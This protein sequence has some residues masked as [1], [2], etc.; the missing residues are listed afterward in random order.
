MALDKITTDIIA[1]NA[2]TSAKIP[3]GAIT[4]SDLGHSLK[5]TD[6]HNLTG[7]YSVHEMIMGKTF[8]LT[9]NVTVNTNLVLVNMSGTGDD[10]T[11]LDDGTATTITGTGTLEG[12]EMLGNTPQRTSLT[13][14]TGE[15]GSV[16]T[17]SP[18]LNL[19]TGTL[20]SGVTFPAGHIL[21]TRH[22]INQNIAASTGNTLITAIA[23]EISLSNASNNIL[24]MSTTP[25][26]YQTY[27]GSSNTSGSTY[28]GFQVRSSGTGVSAETHKWG[29]WSSTG[30]YGYGFSIGSTNELF[31]KDLHNAIWL[32][33]PGTTNP[34]TITVEATGKDD[35]TMT[36]NYEGGSQPY[37]NHSVMILHEIQV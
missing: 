24:V 25:F 34:T 20:G 6:S 32:F 19:T 29:S 13:G 7:T 36:V 33:T 30:I 35:H 27:G 23:G 37:E 22:H 18:N 1:D 11:I 14:M 31:L 12:G 15:L 28:G 8:T 21:Q 10:V 26:M 16:V 5:P 4:L 17:G 2:V 9:G 3:A